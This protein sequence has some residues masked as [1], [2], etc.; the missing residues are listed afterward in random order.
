MDSVPPHTPPRHTENTHVCHDEDAALAALMCDENLQDDS[1][2]YLS[3]R[4]VHMCVGGEGGLE[5][6][7]VT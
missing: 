3:P 5:T 7:T 2:L 1:A 6:E 4:C